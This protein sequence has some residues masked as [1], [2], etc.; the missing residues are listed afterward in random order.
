MDILICLVQL[1][2]QVVSRSNVNSCIMLRERDFGTI[3]RKEKYRNGGT[4]RL[5]K[6]RFVD[7]VHMSFTYKRNRDIEILKVI[8]V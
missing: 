3:I 4:S 7:I 6:V 8:T 1:S 2:Y 5:R